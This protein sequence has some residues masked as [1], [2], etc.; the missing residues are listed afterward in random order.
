MLDGREQAAWVIPVLA[1]TDG[2]NGSVV[3]FTRP[4]GDPGRL[5]IPAFPRSRPPRDTNRAGEAYAAALATAL[6]EAGWAS[7]VIEPEVVRSAALRA[8][9]AAAL[10]LD[11]TAFGFPTDA[12]ID[13][14]LAEG[15]VS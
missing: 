7:G 5:T 8:S 3:R 11:R 15:F 14:A 6:I 2:P 10:V 9:A 4:D 1:I 12:E 13:A